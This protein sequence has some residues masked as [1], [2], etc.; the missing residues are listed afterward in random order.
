MEPWAALAMLSI[1]IVR[2]TSHSFDRQNRILLYGLADF[3]V[4]ISLRVVATR[5]PA[6]LAATKIKSSTPGASKR[7]MARRCSPQGTRLG[8]DIP[9]VDQAD[10]L[11][12]TVAGVQIGWLGNAANVVRGVSRPA[13]SVLNRLPSRW[14]ASGGRNPLLLIRNPLDV[15]SA[16][17]QAKFSPVLTSEHLC[18]LITL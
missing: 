13:C 16:G 4:G 6:M 12:A 8:P 14:W 18:H 5:W 11:D 15:S 9:N 17:S 3:S 1:F 10:S 7:L 2:R